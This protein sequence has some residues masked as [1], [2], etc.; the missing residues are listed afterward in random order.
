VKRGERKD[1]ISFG[2]NRKA[3]ASAETLAK[4]GR[5]KKDGGKNFHR[6]ESAKV[7][8]GRKTRMSSSRRHAFDGSKHDN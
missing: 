4:F 7:Q 6:Y 2:K 1:Y 5:P 8:E 3:Y